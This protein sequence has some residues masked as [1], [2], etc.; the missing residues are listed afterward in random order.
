MLGNQ[1]HNGNQPNGNGGARLSQ[2]SNRSFGSNFGIEIEFSEVGETNISRNERKKV[3][4]SFVMDML[5]L[6]IIL[7]FLSTGQKDNAGIT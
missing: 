7:S 4:C 1:L 5:F 3:W 2:D 6:T